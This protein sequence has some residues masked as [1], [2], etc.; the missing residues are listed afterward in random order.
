VP[1]C[2]YK[3]VRGKYDFSTTETFLRKKGHSKWGLK[4]KDLK[5]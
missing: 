3:L 1:A 4:K 2:R 5:K